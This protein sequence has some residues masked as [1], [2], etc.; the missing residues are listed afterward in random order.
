L[1]EGLFGESA[2]AWNGFQVNQETVL[3][4]T[5]A[6]GAGSAEHSLI[7]SR[8][9]CEKMVQV[10]TR[11]LEDGLKTQEI[12]RDRVL[13]WHR[14]V[15]GDLQKEAQARSSV[16]RDLA[17]T[18]LTAIVGENCAAFSQIGDGAIVVLIEE[19]YQVVFWPQ[20]GEYV[21]TTNFLTDEQ[22]EERRRAP[23][24]PGESRTLI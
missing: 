24:S 18:L 19:G 7:G 13:E 8:I 15:I 20:S 5:C 21:N 10:I 14:E 17:C 9:A 4:A 23:A 12:G 11:G 22:F 16:P 3:I 6:D 2:T 1:A